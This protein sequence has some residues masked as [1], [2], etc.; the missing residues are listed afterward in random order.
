MFMSTVAPGH[1]WEIKAREE[2]NTMNP[3][4]KNF[5]KAKDIAVTPAKS[6]TTKAYVNP[7]HSQIALTTITISVMLI[8][9]KG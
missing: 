7:A 8:C 1:Y 3:R 5:A 6:S 9:V 2:C 4:K